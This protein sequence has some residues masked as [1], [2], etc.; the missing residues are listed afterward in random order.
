MKRKIAV[1]FTFTFIFLLSLIFSNAET[2]DA[3]PILFSVNILSSQ[4]APVANEWRVTVDHQ[5]PKIGINISY[6][7]YTSWNFI[8]PRTWYYPVGEPGYYDYIPTYEEGGFDIFYCGWSWKLDWDPRGLFD[9]AGLPPNG[10]NIYQ[11]SN[12]TYDSIFEQYTSELDY[13]KRIELGKQLQS[14]LYEELPSIVVIYHRVMI[15]TRVSITGIDYELLASNQYLSEFWNDTDD[16]EIII[17]IPYEIDEYNVITQSY[18]I[19]D[20]WMQ[21]VYRGLFQRVQNSHFF[22]TSIASCYNISDDGKQYNVTIDSNAKFSNSEKVLAEDVKYSYELYIA[23]YFNS[24]KGAF[25]E[26]FLENNDSIITLDD[27]TIQFNFKEK[28]FRALE[29]MSY[30]IIDK[31]IVEPLID[32]YG[33]SV[34]YELP[35]TENVGETLVTAC[36]PFMLDTFDEQRNNLTMIPNPYWHRKQPE[37]E[38]ITIK[39]ISNLDIAISAINS[40]NID[41]MDYNYYPYH[42]QGDYNS[43]V[44]SVLVKN[45]SVSEVIINLKHPIIGTGELTPEGTAEAAKHIRKAISHAIPREEIVEEYLLC[46]GV[47]GVSPMPDACVGYDDTLEYYKYDLELAREYMEKAGYDFTISISSHTF[48]I[49]LLSLIGLASLN[50]FYKK[51]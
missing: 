8:M 32:L 37:L 48:S 17:A 27:T 15:N 10:D 50:Y 24:K 31:S 41:I 1:V 28:N 47:P 20:F 51:K 30:G 21:N 5:L 13:D 9:T 39:F 44:Q 19:G 40:G 25:I 35:F 23:D 26:R 22:E 6:R 46:V 43:Y 7:D 49:L 45:P 16:Q 34:F 4:S 33:D 12:S 11:F 3:V 18:H 2:E 38:Q 42:N 14:I 29:V 36:G